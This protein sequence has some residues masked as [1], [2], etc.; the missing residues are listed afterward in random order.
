MR[1]AARQNQRPYAEASNTGLGNKAVLNGRLG[2]PQHQQERDSN[3]F[4]PSALRHHLFAPLCFFWRAF[5]SK[6]AT[7]VT[8]ANSE[9]PLMIYA[10]NSVW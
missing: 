6:F 9:F 1:G 4:R 3:A 2:G 8:S 7:A 5:A 10:G